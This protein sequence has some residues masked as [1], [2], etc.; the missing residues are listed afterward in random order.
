MQEKRKHEKSKA[1]QQETSI[2]ILTNKTIPTKTKKK[3]GFFFK[4]RKANGF[5][6]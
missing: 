4:T 3:H 2:A 1:N 6:P 5:L